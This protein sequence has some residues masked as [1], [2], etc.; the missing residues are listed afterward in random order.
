RLLQ[1]GHFGEHRRRGQRIAWAGA[2]RNPRNNKKKQLSSEGAPEDLDRKAVFSINSLRSFRA[3]SHGGRIP[4]VSLRSTPGYSPL[5]PSAL[6][7]VD[8]WMSNLAALGT[9]SRV[10]Y[11]QIDGETYVRTN[12]IS[13]LITVLSLGLLFREQ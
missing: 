12:Q 11:W 4:G 3:Q 5:A 2:Q 8:F 7:S 1:F 6:R 9:S 10:R 13:A